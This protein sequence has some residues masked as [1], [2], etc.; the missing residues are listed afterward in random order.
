MFILNAHQKVLRAKGGNV[1]TASKKDVFREVFGTRSYGCSGEC[2]C[3]VMHYDTA[4]EWD[5]DHHNETL[6]RVREW[7]KEKPENYQFH[8]AAIKYVELS[9]F[10]YVIGC[11]CK[12]D[13]LLFSVLNEQKQAVLSY[14][15]QTKDE[16]S[17]EDVE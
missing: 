10:L 14:Y 1:R 13:E 15:K 4:N 11:R 3:G 9:G 5:D 8:D 12:Q 7:A 2:A 6:P 17:V 16:I